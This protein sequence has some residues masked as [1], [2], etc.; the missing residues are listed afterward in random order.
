MESTLEYKLGLKADK[1]SEKQKEQKQECGKKGL[2]GPQEIGDW[3]GDEGVCKK[4]KEQ[5][6]K[7]KAKSPLSPHELYDAKIEGISQGRQDVLDHPEQFGLQKPAEWSEEDE[8]FLDSIEEAIHSYYDLNHA[9]QYDYWLEEKLKS[10]R[11]Q[12]KQEWSEEDEKKLE[13]VDD[14]LWMLDDYLGND[15][16]ICEEKTARLRDEIHNELFPWLKS[17]R[18]QKLDA[19]KLENFDPVDVLNRIKTEW[20]MAWE[21]VVGNQ[22]WSEEDEIHRDFILESLEDQIRFCKKNAEGAYYANQIRTAQNWLKDLSLSLK[23]HN[24][25]VEKLC[26]N[27]W[28]E[29]DEKMINTLVSYVG[30]PSC[31]NLKCPREKL[32]AFIES[33]PKKFSSQSKQEWSEEDKENI[34]SICLY[35]D[36]YCRSHEKDSYGVEECKYLKS[37]LK[38]RR[39]S[40]KPSEEH[41]K[42]LLMLADY[43]ESEGG[44][45]NAKTLR[46]FSE[47]LRKLI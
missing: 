19:S 10:L 8:S 30:N 38:S 33:L 37:W 17:L 27:E 14:L 23:K 41:L 22:E 2:K 18:T 21:K 44:T 9:P 46:E 4:Q 39:P 3:R 40:W 43:F 36:D 32:V 15:C 1:E 16:S 47:D 28:T 11:P 12:P 45:S 25:A 31:W 6:P 5:K 24:E 34:N 42:Y 7:A 29:E 20:P 35:L 26:S 13:R